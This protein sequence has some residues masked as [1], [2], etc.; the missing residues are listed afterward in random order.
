MTTRPRGR[1]KADPGRD[2]RADLLRTSRE[3]LE[4]EGP[5]A[6]SMREVARRAGCTHQAPYHYFENRDAILTE[7]VRQGFQDLADRLRTAHDAAE[8]D[9]VRAMLI[10]SARAY[11]G[12]ALDHPGLFRVMFRP[13]M[14]N[15]ERL[16][17]LRQSE[18]SAYSELERLTRI[19]FGEQPSSHRADILWALVHG[20]SCLAIDGP[21]E[22]LASDDRHR[23]DYLSEIYQRIADLIVAA[24][25]A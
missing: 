3:V 1:P 4:E 9:G 7:L 14:Y 10:A 5:S 8:S 15:Q 23:D 2:L 24:I 13:D 16:P 19:T 18:G 20:L 12:F 6:L 21:A 25:G 11:V 22:G 17:N